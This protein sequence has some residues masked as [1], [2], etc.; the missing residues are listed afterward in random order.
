MYAYCI[1]SFAIINKP[2]NYFSKYSLF[3]ENTWEK[4]GRSASYRCKLL[5]N[6]QS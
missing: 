1:H 4:N 2:L 3:K 5:S 6:F